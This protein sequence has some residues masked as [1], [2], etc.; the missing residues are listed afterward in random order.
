M[1]IVDGFEENL[2]KFLSIF[3]VEDFQYC[4][5]WIVYLEFI[6]NNEVGDLIWDKVYVYYDCNEML[7]LYSK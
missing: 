5:K 6:Y 2:S 1:I 7:Y 3:F 4:L